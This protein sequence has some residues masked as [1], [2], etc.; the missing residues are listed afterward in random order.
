MENVNVGRLR[1]TTSGKRLI[2]SH[3]VAVR[4]DR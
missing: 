1:T 3:Q 4:S 2:W